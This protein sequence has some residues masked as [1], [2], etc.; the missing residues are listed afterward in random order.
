MAQLFRALRAGEE[1]FQ[2]SA[3]V[4]SGATDHDGQVISKVDLR[5]HLARLASIFARGDVLSGIENIE[6]MV[7]RARARGGAGLGRTDIKLPHHCDRIAVDN[8][9]LE[10]LSE[11]ERQR[12]LPAGGWTEDH[13]QERFGCGGLAMAVILGGHVQRRLP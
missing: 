11:R 2:Q 12:G 5:K 6:K 7:G 4:Q 1:S 13:Q 3:Q 10:L 9:A 8:L